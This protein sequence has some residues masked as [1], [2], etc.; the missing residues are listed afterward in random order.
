MPSKKRVL[1]VTL[2]PAIDLSCSLP[3][4][5]P[6]QV[7]RVAASRTD[8]GGKG[9][10]I[11]RLLRQFELSVTATG[12]LGEENPEIFEKLFATSEIKD[13]FLRVPGETRVGIKILDSVSHTTTDLNL[14]GLSLD[15]SNIDDLFEIVEQHAKKA[16]IT[17]IAG[18]VPASL[19]PEIMGEL[20]VVVKK[21]GGKVFVD[22]SGPALTNAIDAIPSL[23]KPNVDELSEYVGRPLSDPSDI[24]NEA[25][26]LQDRGIE[27]VVV[28]LG[29][30]GALFVTGQAVFGTTPPAIQAV[31]TV[32][33][34]DA[35]IGS[36]AAGQVMGLGV[37]ECARL[38]TAVSAAVVAQAGPGLS[39]LDEAK[40]LQNQVLIHQNISDGGADE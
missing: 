3:G 18:S 25:H 14:P 34:G 2:N 13:V 27:T 31:S 37:E 21:N 26:K 22:T 7:N 8:A 17:I 28:S 36:F 39:T 40:K 33:A 9:V 5:L 35:M 15:K 20:V 24:I 16:A 19:S 10:N 32:G 38:A 1:T 6:G 12:F 4:L 11:A 29:E 30:R 23:I